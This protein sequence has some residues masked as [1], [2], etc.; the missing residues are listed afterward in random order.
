MTIKEANEVLVHGRLHLEAVKTSEVNRIDHE[1]KLCGI[2]NGDPRDEKT[3]SGS[4]E[5]IRRN[6]HQR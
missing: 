1:S 4:R 5:S 3:H 6:H 2:Q